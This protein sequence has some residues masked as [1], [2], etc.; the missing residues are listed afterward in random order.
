MKYAYSLKTSKVRE[1]DFPY[2]GRVFTNPETVK[3]FLSVLEDF[4]IEKFIIMYLNAK[5][6]L[7]CIQIQEGT[8]DQ[9]SVYPRE[10]AKHAILSGA[11]SVIFAH[12]HPSGVA[13]PS[14]ADKALTGR[15]KD[16]LALVDIRVLDHF[17]IGGVETVSFAERGLI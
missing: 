10:V 4:D 15:L 12:N 16:A 13:E 14:A 11:S 6:K 17:V 7:I 2:N 3:D 8:V 9:T 5:N 1:P